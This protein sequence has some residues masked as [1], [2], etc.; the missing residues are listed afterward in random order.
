MFVWYVANCI[1]HSMYHARS[2]VHCFCSRCHCFS[3]RYGFCDGVVWFFSLQQATLH[4]NFPP[5]T[6]FVPQ[7]RCSAQL[8]I[9]LLAVKAT[10]TNSSLTVPITHNSNHRL[11]T[12][13][14][15][16]TPPHVLRHHYDHSLH[17]HHRSLRHHG[18][19]LPHLLA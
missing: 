2:H 12:V 6:P 10:L 4:C 8:R 14:M 18:H 1:I 13:L 3:F 17:L 9:I 11:H 5:F 7:M 15:A 16:I 19:S